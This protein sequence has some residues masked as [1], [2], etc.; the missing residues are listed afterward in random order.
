VREYKRHSQNAQHDLYVFYFPS[1]HWRGALR[2]NS[3]QKI[4]NS[5]TRRRQQS[6]LLSVTNNHEMCFMQSLKCRRCSSVLSQYI[7]AAVY[8]HS[9]L[10]TNTH[11]HTHTHTHSLSSHSGIIRFDTRWYVWRSCGCIATRAHAVWSS[12][13]QWLS[14]TLLLYFGLDLPRYLF[15]SRDCLP[16]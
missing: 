8:T 15:E 5:L 12:I 3:S 6:W 9:N 16:S 4:N 14:H 10:H 2:D 7:V 13:V 11:R 1:L